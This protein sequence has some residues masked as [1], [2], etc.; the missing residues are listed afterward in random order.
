MPR[1]L[2]EVEQL[3]NTFELLWKLCFKSCSADLWNGPSATWTADLAILVSTQQ[4]KALTNLPS[5][6]SGES[7]PSWFN[8]FSLSGNSLHSVQKRSRILETPCMALS[9]PSN[10]KSSAFTGHLEM[11]QLGSKKCEHA[12]VISRFNKCL[13]VI[14]FKKHFHQYPGLWRWTTGR[15]VSGFGELLQ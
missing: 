4:E 12:Q 10:W 1:G 11:D 2:P 9:L 6:V 3:V 13:R 8:L 5:R 14:K 7:V 15:N